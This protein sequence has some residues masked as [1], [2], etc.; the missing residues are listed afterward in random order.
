MQLDDIARR[1][2]TNIKP[3]GRTSAGVTQRAAE[4]HGGRRR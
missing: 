1:L 4:Q 2:E 3:S